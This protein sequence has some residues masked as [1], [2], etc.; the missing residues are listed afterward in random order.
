MALKSSFEAPNPSVFVD[1]FLV[2]RRGEK[3][4]R[5]FGHTKMEM[6]NGS[7]ELIYGQV[8]EHS[9][10]PTVGFRFDQLVQGGYQ[11]T[12]GH[13]F[14]GTVLGEGLPSIKFH[15]PKLENAT[16]KV[17]STIHVKTRSR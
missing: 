7:A 10:G 17:A 12:T 15:K 8:G 6:K 11:V 13:I 9:E 3:K 4:R 16:S 1:V 5:F 14:G 2:R